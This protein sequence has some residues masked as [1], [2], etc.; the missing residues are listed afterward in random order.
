MRRHRHQWTEK[1]RVFVSP[2]PTLSRFRS[3]NDESVERALFGVTSIELRC[4]CGDVTERQL[5][6]NHLP[7]RI[8]PSTWSDTAKIAR[9]VQRAMH[10]DRRS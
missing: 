8:A 9:E 4:E 7:P 3:N 2:P 5:L 10:Q 1:A 6:G